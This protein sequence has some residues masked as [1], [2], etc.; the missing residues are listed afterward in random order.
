MRY[1]FKTWLIEALVVVLMMAIIV[2]VVWGISPRMG[3]S[4]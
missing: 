4:R 3:W 1:T 2:A